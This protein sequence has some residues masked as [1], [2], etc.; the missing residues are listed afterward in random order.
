MNVPARCLFKGDAAEELKEVA[1]YLLD[2]TLPDGAWDTNDFVPDF[3]KN[4][5]TKHWG[6]NTG[7]FIRTTACMPEV[8]NHYRKFTLASREGYKKRFF[9][10]FWNEQYIRLYFPHIAD[11]QDRVALWFLRD[12]FIIHSMIAEENAGTI[13]NNITL[14]PEL[15]TH[16]KAS[17]LSFRITEYDLEP[18]YKEHAE[19]DMLKLADALKKSFSQELQAYTEEAIHQIIIAPITKMRNYGFSRKRNLYMLAAWIIFFGKDFE[20]KDPTGI[21]LNICQSD[22]SEDDKMDKIKQRIVHLSVWWDG[23]KDFWGSTWGYLKSTTAYVGDVIWDAVSTNPIDTAKLLGRAAWEGTES[24]YAQLENLVEILRSLLTGNIDKF[25]EKIQLLKAL[26]T[27]EGAIGTFG[28]LIHDAFESGV[29]WLNSLIEMIRRTPVLGLIASTAMRV[30]MMM[31]PN[32]WAEMVG[33][34]SGFIIPEIIIWLICLLINALASSSGIGAAPAVAALAARAASTASK[35]RELIKGTGKAF[36]AIAQ[37]LDHLQ[38][39]IK[40]I[41]PLGRK[42]RDSIREKAIGVVDKTQKWFM[43]TRYYRQRLRQLKT[44][45]PGAHGPQRHEGE[46][47]NQSLIDRV[48]KGDDPMT[49]TTIDGVH[50]RKH[51]QVRKA[52]KFKTPVDYVR[53]DEFI[54]N[55]ADFKNSILKGSDMFDITVPISDPK[56]FGPNAQSRFLGKKRIGSKQNPTGLQDLDFRN[57]T[58][59]A[60]YKKRPNGSYGLYTMYPETSDVF[61]TIYPWP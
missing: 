56:L 16:Y 38:P 19:K 7:V 37:F 40:K 10:T 8:W 36:N 11:N 39:I 60:I 45:V 41:S 15:F 50:G 32:F 28:K 9:V 30:I 25:F 51:F 54:R 35:I 44:D 3:H 61:P 59:K 53:A 21:L 55:S 57:G 48:M 2:M 58:I 46:V 47:T 52:T 1:P 20:Q 13:V 43:P 24:I 17:S 6:K 31:T 14:K 42:L 26:K 34:G 22:M 29:E 49:G 27:A 33:T 4:F 23:E 5:F 18:F 12:N